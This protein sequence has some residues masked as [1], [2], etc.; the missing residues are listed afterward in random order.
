MSVITPDI[1]KKVLERDVVNLVARAREGK[2]LTQAQ[3][4]LIATYSG[5][6]SKADVLEAL[7]DV[8]GVCCPA[9]STVIA[10]LREAMRDA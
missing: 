9:C 2:P 6:V 5:M 8:E 1:A 4:G 7:Q 10:K 3:R